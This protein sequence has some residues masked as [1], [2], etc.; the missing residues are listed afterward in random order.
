MGDLIY[1]IAAWILPLMFALVLSSL[2]PALL[3]GMLGDGT[4]RE[5]GRLSLNPLK[6]VDPLGTILVPLVLIIAQAP[7][8]G[9][10]KPIP[11]NPNRLRNPRLDMILVALSRPATNLFLAALAAALLGLVIAGNGDVEMGA[12]AYFV[13]RNL[14]NFLAI[15]LFL[16]VFNLLP[17]PPFPGYQ[18]VEALWPAPP[19]HQ[20]KVYRY[21]FAIV[22]LLV[23]VLPLLSPQLDI[24]GRV[25]APFVQAMMQLFLGSVGIST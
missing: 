20:E 10:A 15:N 11:I 8:L 16:L 18:I 5:M 1:S 19:E 13:A 3:A 17:I 7:V 9:W 2:V 12:L 14:Y 4:A 21:S 23:F 25:I 24:L 22:L 6:H